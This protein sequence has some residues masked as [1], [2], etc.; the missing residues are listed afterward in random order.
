[1]PLRGANSGIK[2]VGKSVEEFAMG[3]YKIIPRCRCRDQEDQLGGMR[4]CALAL[5]QEISGMFN[6][7]FICIVLK[8]CRLICHRPCDT[9]AIDAMLRSKTRNMLLFL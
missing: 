6:R 8:T 2:S 3:I 4:T 7:V 9:H 1:M 5:K